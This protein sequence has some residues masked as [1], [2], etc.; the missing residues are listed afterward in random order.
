MKKIKKLEIFGM[1]VTS[2]M[3]LGKACVRTWA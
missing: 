3:W 1:E 2:D